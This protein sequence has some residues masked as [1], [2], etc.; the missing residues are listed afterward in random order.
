MLLKEDLERIQGYLEGYDSARE[1]L[2]ECSRKAV[3]LAAWAMLQ[4]IGCGW[5]RLERPLGRWRTP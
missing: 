2:L 1:R 4:F 5:R 3:R